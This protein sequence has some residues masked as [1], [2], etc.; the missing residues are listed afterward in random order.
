MT[1]FV[2]TNEAA[3]NAVH[4]SL[5]RNDFMSCFSVVLKFEAHQPGQAENRIAG[6]LSMTRLATNKSFVTIP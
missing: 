5:D 1:G 6:F 2:I 4:P 3:N